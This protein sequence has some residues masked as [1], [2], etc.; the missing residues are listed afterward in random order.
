MLTKIII[1]Y[2]ILINIGNFLLFAIDKHLSIKN[3]ERIPESTLI[4]LSAMGGALGGL[5]SMYLFRHKTRQAKFYIC[6]P[7][8]LALH[9]IVAILMIF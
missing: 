6:L 3:K 9:V 5:C 1:Y 8:F 7:L 4:L 2:F